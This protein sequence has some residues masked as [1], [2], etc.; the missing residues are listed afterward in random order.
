[1]SARIARRFVLR[2]DA[3][4]DKTTEEWLKGNAAYLASTKPA[5]GAYQPGI[6]IRGSRISPRP[7]H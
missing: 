3:S 6:D 5:G 4:K 1:M 7:R 2:R